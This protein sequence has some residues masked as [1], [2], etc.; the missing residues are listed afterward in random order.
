MAD[1]Q[2]IS[3]TQITAAAKDSVAKAK[4][5]R[6][7]PLANP[8]ILGF[9]PPYWWLGYVIDNFDAAQLAAAQSMATD[10]HGGVANAIAAVKGATPGI[11]FV[12][13]HCTIGFQLPPGTAATAE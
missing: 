1:P 9:V 6:T 10:V 8:R 13:G 3:I 11:I 2:T 7:G 12:G 4:V 5:S